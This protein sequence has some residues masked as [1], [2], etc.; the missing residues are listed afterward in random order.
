MNINK[1]LLEDYKKEIIKTEQ[2]IVSFYEVEENNIAIKFGYNSDYVYQ[3]DTEVSLF[4]LI[5]FVYSKI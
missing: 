3:E 1:K 4:D 2:E 5:S